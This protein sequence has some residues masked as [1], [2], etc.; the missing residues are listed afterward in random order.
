MSRRKRKKFLKE[1][2]TDLQ[3]NDLT[4]SEKKA[5]KEILSFWGLEEYKI[6]VDHIFKLAK[7]DFKK[8]STLAS[9]KK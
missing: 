3:K 2:S 5:D 6:F 8:F 7:K 9:I 4:E 1:N